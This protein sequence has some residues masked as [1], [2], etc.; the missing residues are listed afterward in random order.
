MADRGAI[1]L[2]AIRAG[3]V[4]SA[5][6]QRDWRVHL[7]SPLAIGGMLAGPLLLLLAIGI[8]LGSAIG[9]GAQHQILEVI[10]PGLVGMGVVLATS[11]RSIAVFSDRT[12]GLTDEIVAGPVTV[13]IIVLAQ[14]LSSTTIATLQGLAVFAL[15]AMLGLAVVPAHWLVFLIALVAFAFACAATCNA[16]GLMARRPGSIQALLNLVVNPLFFLSGALFDVS[17]TATPIRVIALLNPFHYGVRLLQD[18]Y[19]PGGLD[20]ALVLQ[21]AAVLIG[22]AIV[23]LLVSA[24]SLRRR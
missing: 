20:L 2:P 11:Q 6:C 1:A 23:A 19:N 14:T 13:R 24:R 8:G 21:S 7:R 22:V 5:Y 17:A 4:A 15:A 10:V 9:G 18:A 16:M 12:S 3:H